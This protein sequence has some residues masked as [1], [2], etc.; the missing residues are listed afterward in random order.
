M[1]SLCV[2][3]TACSGS[4]PAA[5]KPHGTP[6]ASTPTSTPT[7]SVSTADGTTLAGTSPLTGEKLTGRLPQ[8]PVF[9]VKIDNTDSSAPQ[10]GLGGADMVVEELVEGGL[11]RLAVFYYQHI[12]RVVGP[13]RSMRASDVGIVKPVQATLVA[14]GGARPTIRVLA[15]HHVQT[16]LDGT[17]GFYRVNTRPEPYNL[18]MHLRGLAEH[19][20]KGWQQPA[21]AYLPFGAAA[22]PGRTTV[23]SMSAM[24]SSG[25]T[26]HWS[27]NGRV[28]VR[29]GSFAQPGNDFKADNVLF[30]RVRIGN[31]GYRDPAGNP[32]P[33]TKF[34]GTGQAVL[35]HGDKALACSWS[36]QHRASPLKLSTVG[37][38]PV[39]LPPGHTWVELVPATSGKVTLGK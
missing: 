38:K 37:G 12:P 5:G 15:G 24:F 7:Q 6:P 16:H 11:T 27:W 28:W 3:L 23:K 25:H 30:L 32:V 39:T 31:A 2:A 4:S 26:T 29:P 1:L 20:P 8:H 36:K 13:V 9:V 33:E 35:V 19:P 34:Y 17:S 21:H 22:F 14:S 18:F 10:V